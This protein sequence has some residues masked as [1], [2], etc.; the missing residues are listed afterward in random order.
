VQQLGRLVDDLL[1]VGR[2]TTGK[3]TLSLGPV[4]LAETA[5]RCVAGLLPSDQPARHQMTV[6]AEPAWV[7][8]DQARIEQIVMNLLSNA[9]KYT[10]PGG[11]IEIVVEGDGRTARLSVRDTGAGMTPH[12][13]DRVFD[14]FFQGERTLDRAEGGLGI[15]LT[16]VRRLVELHGGRVSARSPGPG[17]GSTV[18]VELPQAAAPALAPPAARPP[19]PSPRRVLLVEDSRDSR[20]MLRFLLER[21]GHEVH[22]AVDGPGGVEAILAVRPD[23]A[24]IDVGLPGLDG[25]EVAR[26]ARAGGA[27][28]E[29]KM[30]ALTGYGLPDDQRRSR[31]AG[32]DA[33]LVKPVDP[34]RLAEVIAT[35]RRG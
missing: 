35:A 10:P 23:I 18:I 33:H 17:L 26:R 19:E 24:L 31:E 16:L 25:Y 34:A 5:R 9:V 29:V 2:V 1:D 22:E 14:L 11:A 3:I 4:D 13:L 27:G 8:A 30:V 32:F 20:E 15:G 7:E 21:E 6:R 28:P 12:M